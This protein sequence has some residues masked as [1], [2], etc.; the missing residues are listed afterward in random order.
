[1][2][3]KFWKKDEP[4]PLPEYL[5]PPKPP[6]REKQDRSEWRKKDFI[7]RCVNFRHITSSGGYWETTN[8]QTATLLKVDDEFNALAKEGL[9]LFEI[10]PTEFWENRSHDRRLLLVKWGLTEKE[11]R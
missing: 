5:N 7:C 4:R 1:M 11:I 2:K 10:P 3:F 6:E 9:R 8:T